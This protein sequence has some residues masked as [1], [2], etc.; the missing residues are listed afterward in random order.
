MIAVATTRILIEAYWIPAYKGTTR[1]ATFPAFLRDAEAPRWLSNWFSQ[2][3]DTNSLPDGR[4][5]STNPE[6][7]RLS[8]TSPD[9][10]RTLSV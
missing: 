5:G 4:K 1:G 3:P 7:N 10:H 8:T 9:R 2:A 6:H